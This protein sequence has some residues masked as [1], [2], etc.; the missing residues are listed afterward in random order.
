MMSAVLDGQQPRFGDEAGLIA[1]GNKIGKRHR[2]ARDASRAPRRTPHPRRDPRTDGEF[3]PLAE[4][5]T[6]EGKGMKIAI[7]EAYPS[8][9]PPSHAHQAVVRG[10]MGK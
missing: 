4:T 2:P 8:S 5:V 6:D 9:S 10:M 3:S 7:T 1:D